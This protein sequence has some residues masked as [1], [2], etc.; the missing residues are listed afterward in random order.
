[1]LASMPCKMAYLACVLDG[2]AALRSQACLLVLTPCRLNTS[3][4]LGWRVSF[5]CQ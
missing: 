4:V 3:R 1:M 5:L 2:T